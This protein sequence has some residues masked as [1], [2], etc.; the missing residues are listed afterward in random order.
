M[1]ASS[2]SMPPGYPSAYWA[3]SKPFVATPGVWASKIVGKGSADVSPA[4]CGIL[5]NVL[6][7]ISSKV[8]RTSSTSPTP[9]PTTFSTTGLLSSVQGDRKRQLNRYWRHRVATPFFRRSSIKMKFI[10]LVSLTGAICV[11]PSLAQV[12]PQKPNQEIIVKPPAS[13]A[14]DITKEQAP[15]RWVLADQ[16]QLLDV[17]IL[18]R[19][20]NW[21]KVGFSAPVPP[22]PP[23]VPVSDDA[24]PRRSE[25]WVNMEMIVRI[26]PEPKEDAESK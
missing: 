26:V 3:S 5:P 25:C 2:A 16:S 21:A 12:S 9:R 22:R 11:L 7:G 15:V 20:G 13:A 6:R 19:R 17:V 10:I 8:I 18:E 1:L 4:S 24:K 14:A 23:L